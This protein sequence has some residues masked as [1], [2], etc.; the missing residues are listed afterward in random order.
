MLP[1]FG[2]AFEIFTPRLLAFQ[3]L[4]IC[5][6]CTIAAIGSGLNGGGKFLQGDRQPMSLPLANWKAVPGVEIYSL[7]G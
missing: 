7:S 4:T 3:A 2:R 5:Y 6:S 1:P